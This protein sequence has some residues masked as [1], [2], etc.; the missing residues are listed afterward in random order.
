[1]QEIS[2]FFLN[3]DIHLWITLIVATIVMIYWTISKI[4]NIK[5][6]DAITVIA[7]I[8]IPAVMSFSVDKLLGNYRIKGN[9][10]YFIKQLEDYADCEYAQ[11][12]LGEIR[13]DLLKFKN[14]SV[15]TYN[16]VETISE[17]IR[18]LNNA[19]YHAIYIDHYIL[20]WNEEIE[21]LFQANIVALEKRIEIKRLF[22]IPEE[23]WK[24]N[25]KMETAKMIMKRQYDAGIDVRYI[26]QRDILKSDINYRYY[27]LNNYCLIDNEL[28]A[29]IIP[30]SQI[31]IVPIRSMLVW[32]KERIEE[33]NTFQN[34]LISKY[35]ER[36]E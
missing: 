26:R 36:Y 29:I 16:V 8:G 20:S 32:N 31:K 10:D 27:A 22:I 33:L 17:Q 6:I 28:L 9:V 23:I 19:K 24:N 5:E 13:R 3:T 14:R 15:E 12:K 1:M 35:L 2:D 21:L 11:D 18:A 34:L 7:I 25:E 4:I 30:A